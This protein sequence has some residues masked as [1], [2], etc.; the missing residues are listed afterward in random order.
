MALRAVRAMTGAAEELGNALH[1]GRLSLHH[2]YGRECDQVQTPSLKKSDD[3]RRK[4]A[5]LRN[6]CA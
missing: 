4:V 1:S 3:K 5:E 6:E 2:M